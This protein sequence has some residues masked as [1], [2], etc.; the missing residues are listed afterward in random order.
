M[1]AETEQQNHQAEMPQG[2]LA[3][4]VGWSIIALMAVSFFYVVVCIAA[5][6]WL[7]FEVPITDEDMRNASF[8]GL[9]FGLQWHGAMV[10]GLFALYG[11]GELLSLRV[12]G[13]LPVALGMSAI[14]ATS[15]VSALRQGILDGDI[16]IGCYS[17]ESFE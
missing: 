15:E 3:K 5:S 13:L 9:R 17:Y 16:K 10:G 4:V 12:S 6:S 14:F 2:P 11:L 1:I 7:S 8:L